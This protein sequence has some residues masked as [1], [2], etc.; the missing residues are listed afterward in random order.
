MPDMNTSHTF[1]VPEA[2]KYEQYINGLQGNKYLAS[3]S[4]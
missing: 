1:T 3:A 2:H 4:T